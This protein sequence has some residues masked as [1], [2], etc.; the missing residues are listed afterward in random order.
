[1]QDNGIIINEINKRID[2]VEEY[3]RKVYEEMIN[4]KKDTFENKKDIDGLGQVF[5]D[6]L[7]YWDKI[8]KKVDKVNWGQRILIAMSSTIGT[9]LLGYIINEIIFK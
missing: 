2:R 9:L 7:E 4:L 1:M 5:R 6:H 3:E 8:E